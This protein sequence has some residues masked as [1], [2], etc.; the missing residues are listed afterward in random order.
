MF[1]TPAGY[2]STTCPCCGW[3]KHLYLKYNNEK[4]AKFELSK[5]MISKN[6]G[7]YLIDYI[8]PEDIRKAKTNI[9]LLKTHRRLTSKDQLRS[10]YN[11]STKQDITYVITEEL[12]KLFG[13]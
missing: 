5:I 9:K 10:Q 12:D 8:V 7:N 11:I 4:T 1:Y 3:R 13:P 6:D 2:T